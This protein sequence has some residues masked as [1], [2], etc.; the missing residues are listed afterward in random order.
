MRKE[1]TPRTKFVWVYKF[2]PIHF[3]GRTTFVSFECTRFIVSL[4]VWHLNLQDSSFFWTYD[5]RFTSVCK[6][7]R[8]SGR[9]AFV[10]LA[11]TSFVLFFLKYDVCIIC[12]YKFH[13]F[14]GCT[15][16][17]SFASTSLIFFRTYDVC[18]MCVYRF[19]SFSGRTTF[20]FSFASTSFIVFLDVWHLF[21]LRL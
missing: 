15:T 13:R 4:D 2:Y 20:F 21:L 11:S 16:F 9:M 19:H 18:F 7:H 10:S 1:Y 6:F 8:F 5:I 17:V 12:F 14:F 3:S